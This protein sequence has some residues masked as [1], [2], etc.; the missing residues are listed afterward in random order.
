MATQLMLLPYLQEWDGTKLNLRLLAAPQFSPLDPLAPGEPAFVDAD[1]SFELRLV[2]GLGAIPTTTTAFTAIPE[3]GPHPPQ[4]R[5][6]C[7]ALKANLPIDPTIT[8]INPR[9]LSVR[10]MKYAPPPY[11]AAS[12]YAE[13]SNPFVTTTKPITVL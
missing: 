9:T 13:G 6:I 11:R 12:G 7:Q 5:A 2:A 3:V 8:P 1:F 4:A 10:F